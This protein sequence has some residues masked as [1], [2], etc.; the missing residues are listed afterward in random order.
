MKDRKAIA[1]IYAAPPD[2]TG[3]VFLL[4]FADSRK[5]NKEHQKRVSTGSSERKEVGG[6]GEGAGRNSTIKHGVI[7][8]SPADRRWREIA[9]Q[10]RQ[11][12]NVLS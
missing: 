3:L 12:Q 11:I 4:R 6:R 9:K 7:Q 2:P 10:P 8:A 1:A 5:T